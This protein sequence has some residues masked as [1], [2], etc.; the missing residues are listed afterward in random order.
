LERLGSVLHYDDDTD[1]LSRIK[2]KK[3]KTVHIRH[4]LD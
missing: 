4:P 1:E 3:I 2:S